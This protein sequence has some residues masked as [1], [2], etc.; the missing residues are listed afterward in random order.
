M[1]IQFHECLL[2]VS[3]NYAHCV[4]CKAGRC[5]RRQK[6]SHLANLRDFSMRQ[7]ACVCFSILCIVAC[8]MLSLEQRCKIASWMDVFKSVTV[9]QRR[10]RALYGPNHAP[11]R[12]TI[13]N[14][15][16]KFMET[17]SVLDR[18]R[19]GRPRSGR[20]DENVV[21]VRESFHRS[22]GKK[23][24]RGAAVELNISTTSIHRILRQCLGMFPYKI[25]MAHK[26]EPQDYDH[27]V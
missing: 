16:T 27:R 8:N 12:N 7:K 2:A 24:V 17:G 13:L 23:S 14:T 11:D 1:E 22:Q 10:F 19:S 20:S 15:H 21:I 5:L 25:Q 4:N 26:L 3:L 18:P 9:V 6:S